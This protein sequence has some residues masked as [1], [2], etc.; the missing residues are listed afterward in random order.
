MRVRGAKGGHEDVELVMLSK[1][2]ELDCSVASCCASALKRHSR[3]VTLLGQNSSSITTDSWLFG[4]DRWASNFFQSSSAIGASRCICFL[5]PSRSRC[6]SMPSTTFLAPANLKSGISFRACP[7]SD[8]SRRIGPIANIR[9]FF[10]KPDKS[11][12]WWQRRNKL[13]SRSFHIFFAFSA[14]K[15]KLVKIRGQYCV[16]LRIFIGHTRPNKSVLQWR[17]S[18]TF[19]SRSGYP[20]QLLLKFCLGRKLIN[21]MKSV[22]FSRLNVESQLLFL[23]VLADL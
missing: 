21:E 13:G 4:T 12:F 1:P 11:L 22:A 23:T 6:I 2:G 5:T 18:R 3:A 9:L 19:V 14:L 8:M 15:T 16:A 17:T 7:S 10:E 20:W